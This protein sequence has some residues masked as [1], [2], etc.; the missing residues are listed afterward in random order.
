MTQLT[1]ISLCFSVFFVALA[2]AGPGQAQAPKP[3][4]VGLWIDHT[5]RG[6]VEISRCGQAL[7]GHIVWLETLV[8]A[9]GQPLT[10][11]YN[12][13]QKLR[14][15]PICGL[16]IIGDAKPMASGA[17]DKGWIYDPEKGKRYDVEVKLVS[18]NKLTVLGYLGLKFLGE[19]FAWT[20][21]QPGLAK[22]TVAEKA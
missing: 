13:D 21:A 1:P 3:D 5:G 10:D 6:A 12:P 9:K 4:A 17:F 8:D 2:A 7:C 22:C 11:G 14:N 19:T 18:P 16:Q 20:R 15:R